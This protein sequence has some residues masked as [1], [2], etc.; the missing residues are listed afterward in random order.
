MVKRNQDKGDIISEGEKIELTAKKV[1]AK[2]G[3]E[4]TEITV[5]RRN[6]C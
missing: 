2:L 4:M 1:V 5:G 6:W 3:L